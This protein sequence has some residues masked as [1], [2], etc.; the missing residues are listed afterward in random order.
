MNL[1]AGSQE[2]KHLRELFELYVARSFMA[3]P[4]RTTNA[5]CASIV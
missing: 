1:A 4:S 5:A 2:T 3:V